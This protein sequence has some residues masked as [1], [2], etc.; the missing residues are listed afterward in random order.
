MRKIKNAVILI[1]LP[2]LC[3][4]ASLMVG[5]YSMSLRE[6]FDT[7]LLPAAADIEHYRVVWY[8]RLPRSVA[9]AMCGAALAVSGAAF[10]GVFRNPLVNS[11]LLGVSNGA[12]FGACV[13]IIFL[14]GGTFTYI[15]S[16]AFAVL[17]VAMSWFAGRVSRVTTSVTLILGGVIVSSFFSALI[18]VM[19]FM[20][21]P[22]SQLP[23]ITF[24]FMGSFASVNYVHFYSFIPMTLGMLL[25]YLSR[26]RINV[27]SMGD[28]EAAALGVDVKRYKFLIVGGAT[29][30]TAS[31]VCISGTIGWVGLVV[32]HIGRMI[33]GNNNVKLIPVSMSLGACFLTVMDIL[34]RNLSTAELPIGIL[35]ALVGTPFFVYLLKKT[36]GGGWT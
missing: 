2:M 7:L 11:G 23:S 18:S 27:L 12:G 25:I 16:F 32:P 24:W 21:D 10:Q 34:S 6:I 17:A 4:L 26:W 15:L 33:V 29:L 36:K 30:A 35:C 3:I 20:A 13:A 22:Y 1:L 14:G 5:R 31:A 28:R 19:K 9:A 8:L